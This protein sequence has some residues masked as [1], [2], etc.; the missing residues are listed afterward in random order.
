MK[1]LYS[2]Q[3]RIAIIGKGNDFI[4][5]LVSSV[6]EFV[7]KSIDL[8]KFGQVIRHHQKDF[9]MMAMDENDELF[10]D[11]QPTLAVITDFS[12]S[13]PQFIN[14][15]TSGGILIYNQN[16]EE[17]GQSLQKAEKYFRKIPFTTPEHQIN[18]QQLFLDTDLGEIAIPL[19]TENISLI[20]ASRLL[21]QQLGIQEEEFYEALIN[22]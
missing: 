20:E 21:C 10:L 16:D 9:V 19:P 4:F 5:D 17:L 15:I 2:Q 7:G 8:V 14:Q 22:Y 6:L 18:Q 1:T 13:Y 11:Y 3:T 12:A